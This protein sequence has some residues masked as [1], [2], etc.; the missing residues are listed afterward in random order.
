MRKI[1]T[2]SNQLVGDETIRYRYTLRNVH[3]RFVTHTL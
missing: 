1:D 2:T 3:T